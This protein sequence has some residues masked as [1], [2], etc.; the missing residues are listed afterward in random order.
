MAPLSEAEASF[1]GFSVA[2]DELSV[3]GESIA[4]R[5]VSFETGTGSREVWFDASGRLMRVSD[6][7]SGFLAERTPTS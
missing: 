4:T 2:D 1:S 5:R 7:A 6:G 3:G